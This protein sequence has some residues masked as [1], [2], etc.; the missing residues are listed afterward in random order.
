M[1]AEAGETS[2]R[3]PDRSDLGERRTTG[4]ML[5]SRPDCAGSNE[6]AAPR[7]RGLRE[8]LRQVLVTRQG[9]LVSRTKA[10][11]ELKSLIVVA[12]EHLR[13]A[14]RPRLA[15][16]LDRIERLTSPVGPAS[17]PSHDLDLRS[18]AA[19][20]VPDRPDRRPR[21]R[22]AHPPPQHPP[23]RRCS[24]TRRRPRRRRPA[25]GQL[26]PPRPCPQRSR[27]RRW[28]CRPSRPAAANAPAIDSAVPETETS[29]APATVA[30]PDCAA[31][32]NPGPRNQTR[33]PRQDASRHPPQPQTRPR[34]T[35]HRRI[36]AATRPAAAFH[37]LAHAA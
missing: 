12:P 5:F 21:R 28:R 29:T 22:T 4:S 32:T 30:I 34:Q 6:Q 19:R 37:G 3:S 14:P 9:V 26:V 2:W 36:Q 25:P 23:D 8:A 1:L 10:I 11:N 31:T 17:T 35:A 20:S 16:Q 7:E 24:P 27:I 13:P 15:K 33:R 18:I